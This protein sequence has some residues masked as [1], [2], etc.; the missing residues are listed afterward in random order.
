MS[1]DN[2]EVLQNTDENYLDNR[3]KSSYWSWHSELVRCIY[4]HSISATYF[5][6]WNEI[7]LKAVEIHEEWACK[8]LQAQTYAGELEY[9]IMI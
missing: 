2:L 6:S 4:S 3:N 7:Q 8:L 5:Q 1:S 9:V